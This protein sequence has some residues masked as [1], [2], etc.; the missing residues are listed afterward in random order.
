MNGM[1][2]LKIKNLLLVHGS[3]ISLIL[4]VITMLWPAL[5]VAQNN[6]HII[7]QLSVQ[8]NDNKIY[9]PVVSNEG[10]WGIAKKLRR[11]N[12]PSIAQMALALFKLNPGAFSNHNMNGLLVGSL[13]KIPDGN[14]IHLISKEDALIYVKQ[15]WQQ[16]NSPNTEWPETQETINLIEGTQTIIEQFAYNQT[17]S[18]FPVPITSTSQEPVL[19]SQIPHVQ[20]DSTTVAPQSRQSSSFFGH[21][22]QLNILDVFRHWEWYSF[23]RI[24]QG[25]KE[26]ALFDFLNI[27]VLTFF[28]NLKTI[29]IKSPI[30]VIL[31]GFAVFLSLV[32][33]FRKREKDLL[34]TEASLSDFSKSSSKS[35]LD[36]SNK[37][38]EMMDW[39][40][41][42]FNLLELDSQVSFND[43]GVNE[44]LEQDAVLRGQDSKMVNEFVTDSLP[45]AAD[46]Q[47]VNIEKFLPPKSNKPPGK[48]QN[49]LEVAF[50]D[51]ISSYNSGCIQD[52]FIANNKEELCF[53]ESGSQPTLDNNL[54]DSADEIKFIKNKTHDSKVEAFWNITESEKTMDSKLLNEFSNF[55]GNEKIDAFIEEFEQ[56][57]SNLSLRAPAIKKSPDELENIIQFKLSVHFIKALSDMMQAT[58]LKNFSNTVIEFLEGILD[59]KTR[60]SDEVSHRLTVVVSFYDQYIFSLKNIQSHKISHLK[61]AK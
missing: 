32:L 5:L 2:L 6:P 60:M 54:F 10:L 42:D 50:G 57:M 26:S 36:S 8:A 20:G 51:T 21:V 12:G 24:I 48:K 3:F 49:L 40:E 39:L 34:L 22:K 17:D 28:N 23:E 27:D 19:F 7:A 15:H 46:L 25:Y 53:E 43:L 33:F 45:L 14:E 56:I 11:N 61:L 9:G 47:Q 58:H 37:S 41:E 1:N 38:P 44:N 52:E 18:D 31:I 16:W 13:L 59:G 4:L 55:K 30:L 29:L 35:V